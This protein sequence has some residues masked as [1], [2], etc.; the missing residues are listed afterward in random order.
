MTSENTGPADG[1][2]PSAFFTSC[3]P[4]RNTRSAACLVNVPLVISTRV[5][6]GGTGRDVIDRIR[7]ASLLV[8]RDPAAV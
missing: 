8:D 1:Q 2:L 6:A 7:W 3:Q 5:A 4:A